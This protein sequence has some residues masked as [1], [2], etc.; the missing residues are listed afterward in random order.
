MKISDNPTK[1]TGPNAEISRYMRVFGYG[2]EQAREV[3]V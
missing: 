2:H 1:A 3:V